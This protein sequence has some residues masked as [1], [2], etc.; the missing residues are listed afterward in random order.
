M[1]LGVAA[2]RPESSTVLATERN[3]LLLLWLRRSLIAI[4]VLC[5]HMVVSSAIKILTQVINLAS[6]LVLHA[7]VALRGDEVTHLH[8]LLLL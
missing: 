2:A 1:V 6:R 4:I 5:N 7:V 8:G 3:I